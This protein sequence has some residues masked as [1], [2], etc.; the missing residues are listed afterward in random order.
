MSRLK[1]RLVLLAVVA[2]AALTLLV[3]A[4]VPASAATDDRG[5]RT[6]EVTIINLTNGQPLTPPIVATHKR[7][8]DVFEVGDPASYEVAQ[9]AENGDFGPLA[10][11]LAAS[12]RVRGIATGTAPLVP[13][14]TPGAAMF[15]DRVTLEISTNGSAKRIS[16]VSMLVCSNDGFVGVD[17][18]KLPRTVGQQRVVVADGY[19]AGSEINTEDF[20]DIVPPCQDWIG[21]SSPDPGTGMSDPALAEG[22]VITHHPGITGGVDLDPAVHGWDDPAVVFIVERTG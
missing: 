21:V 13:F 4:M 15:D 6:Y 3:T 2:V 8:I 17:S 9:I 18:L 7:S 1:K 20:A 12:P 19:D 10:A 11:A 22:G 5:T 16:F 14:G